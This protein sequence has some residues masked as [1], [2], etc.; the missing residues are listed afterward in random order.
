M[1]GFEVNDKFIFFSCREQYDKCEI[2][3]QKLNKTIH[4]V[5]K[6]NNDW[7]DFWFCYLKSDE[8]EFAQR[9]NYRRINERI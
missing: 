7:L 8:T 9:I 2:C 6:N 5:L 4:K 1:E 3:K